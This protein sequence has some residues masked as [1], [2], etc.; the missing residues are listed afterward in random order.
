MREE[1][2][3]SVRSVMDVLNTLRQQLQVDRIRARGQANVAGGAA[4]AS[5]RAH[6][7][8]NQTGIRRVL[9]NGFR[10]Y[11]A[12]KGFAQWGTPLRE[13]FREVYFDFLG[14]VRG[15]IDESLALSRNDQAAEREE[16]AAYGESLLLWMESSPMQEAAMSTQASFTA[17]FTGQETN[18]TS[19]LN[20]LVP[21]LNFA[22]PEMPAR[23]RNAINLAVGRNPSLRTDPARTWA[24][25]PVPALADAALARIDQ[26]EQVMNRGRM[27]LRAAIA[28]FDVWL[29]APAQ[30]ID[31]ADRVDELFHTRDAGY[32]QLLHDRL[33]LM[34]NNLEGRGQLF[35]HTL[36]PGDTQNCTSPTTI[37][38]SPRPYEFIF[39]QFAA[40]LDSN[41]STLLHELAHAVIP[42]RGTRGSAT[43]GAP[44]DRAYAGE[45]LMLHMTTEE[46]L[47]NA[48]S[49]A[50]LITVL[51]G[52]T[53]TT[54]PT[55]TV[56]GCAD[57]GPWLD[58]L[59]V[60]QSAH[61]TAW[62]Y[63]EGARDALDQGVAIQPWLRT[64]IDTHLG[65]P[66]DTDLR[67]ILTDFQNL[68]ADPN[69]WHSGH[70]FTCPAARACPANALAFDN[71]RLYRS[72][73]V[74]SSSR[75]GS[76]APRI[77]PGF[78]SLATADDRARAAHVIISRSFGDSLLIHKNRVWSYAALALELYRI[79]VGAPPA[80]SLAEHQA[81]DQ[82]PGTTPPTSTT[83]PAA[84]SRFSPF[85]DSSRTSPPPR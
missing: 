50:Q 83:P 46:A 12:Q 9:S 68:D 35:A 29:Q 59:A 36:R 27:L 67:G 32:G 74:V 71:R 17:A 7:I 53:P 10:L 75:S 62:G 31:V 76:S 52:L 42:G 48:E 5:R 54:I 28:R 80:S 23:A 69:V 14:E 49:Y 30:P 51:A 26:V 19:V 24:T 40:N 6:A 47:N 56:T 55:D 25:G 61:R 44:I 79:G 72:G 58:A 16:E 41:A 4:E 8:L 78:F 66:S 84:P 1:R 3:D 11:E 43:S 70:T 37:G 63:L 21:S 15:A 33:Q 34:L 65:T 81:A 38:Q 73:S 82:P 45:R 85:S 13:R 20:N 2:S 22:L 57:S 60:A 39:C 77:C 18:L 64:L